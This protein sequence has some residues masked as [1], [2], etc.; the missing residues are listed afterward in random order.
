MAK[1]EVLA[2][3]PA[4][5]GAKVASNVRDWADA[6]R[7]G[8][9]SN[10]SAA[11]AGVVTLLLIVGLVM[12][13]S[14][15]I[16]DAAEVGDPFIVFKRQLAWAIIGVPLFLIA[17]ALDPKIWRT[18]AWPM[19]A[20]S[21]VMLFVVLTPAGIERQGSQRWFG[22]GPLLFQPS[23][24]AKLATPLWLA[25]VLARKR[26]KDGLPIEVRHLLVPAVPLLTVEAM[27][28]MAEPDLGTTLLLAFI[29]GFV[30]FA[31]GLPLRWFAAG[32]AAVASLGL[33]AA[34]QAPYRLARLNG[35]LDPEADP[36]NSG[37]QLL[38]SLY[39]MGSGGWFGLG[40]GSSRGKWN[41]VPNPETDFVFAIIGEEL[42]LLGAIVVLAMFL[43]L[44][45]IGLRIARTA[46]T[47][48]SRTVAWVI[49]AWIVGQGLLNIATVT[50][51]MPIT[52]VTLPLVSVGGSSMVS[53]LVALGILAAIAR[54]T[55]STSRLT[56]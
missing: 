43:A 28:V 20:F 42:G 25:D 54:M 48:F 3:A 56:S 50:G 32:V 10:D 2:R 13:F 47:N 55:A 23:E 26:P 37:F 44:L 45:V 17:A 22:F 1:L 30:L 35:W 53:T 7:S 16:V 6:R 29:V 34:I 18:L 31:E 36:L 38:Q 11:L 4:R 9:W 39:A 19:L 41:F 33:L 40:L 24:L 15:S 52:G 14:A 46:T 21:L 49:T 5:L 27:L 8:P 51:L 12:S